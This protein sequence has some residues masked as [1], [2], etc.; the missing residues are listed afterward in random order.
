MSE[1]KTQSTKKLF[2]SSFAIAEH[3][4]PG[5]L[6]MVAGSGAG[7]LSNLIACL[8]SDPVEANKVLV[9]LVQK[10][11]T[12]SAPLRKTTMRSVM[13]DMKESAT[14]LSLDEIAAAIAAAVA[15][16]GQQDG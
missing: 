7:S 4:H 10:L 2:R 6:K 8:A 1:V 11:M 3:H 14:V 12:Q 5:M 15:A 16:K 13:E 9:P